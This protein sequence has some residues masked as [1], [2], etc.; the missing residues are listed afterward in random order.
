MNERNLKQI[1][2]WILGTIAF[3]TILLLQPNDDSTTW[4]KDFIETK[5][6]GFIALFSAVAIARHWNTEKTASHK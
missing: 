5:T 1:I 4:L 2:L 3:T 6:V